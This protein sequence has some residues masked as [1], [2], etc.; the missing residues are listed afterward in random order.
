MVKTK[1]FWSAFSVTAT[2]ALGLSGGAVWASTFGTVQG[3][4]TDAAG[5]PV[6][7]VQVALPGG[8]S[9]TTDKSGFY[10]LEGIEPGEYQLQASK[11]GYQKTSLDVTITQDVP[12][13]VDVTLSA[14]QKP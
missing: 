1:L 10:D 11:K 2:L 9:V 14:P 4:V 6:A 3:K 12:Q 7:G 13:E 8:G 5:K